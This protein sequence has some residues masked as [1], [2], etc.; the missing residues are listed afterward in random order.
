M[1]DPATVFTSTSTLFTL[2]RLGPAQRRTVERHV[3]RWDAGARAPGGLR[4]MPGC[5][6][7]VAPVPVYAGAPRPVSGYLADA[8]ARAQRQFVLLTPDSAVVCVWCRGEEPVVRSAHYADISVRRLE[9][10]SAGY[11]GLM[12]TGLWTPERGAGGREAGPGRRP[13]ALLL[14]FGGDAPG[15]SFGAELGARAGR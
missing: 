3:R 1:F 5:L 10:D 15:R 2:E 6:T 9:T 12:A 4:R 8:V 7:D 14:H 13:A 11:A